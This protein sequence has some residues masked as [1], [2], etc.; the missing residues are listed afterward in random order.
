MKVSKKKIN[1]KYYLLTKDN[2][3]LDIDDYRL[4][5]LYRGDDIIEYI[6]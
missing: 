6:E 4:L 2:L 1:N 5:G 3:I